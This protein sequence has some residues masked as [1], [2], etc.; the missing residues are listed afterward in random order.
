MPGSLVCLS[1]DQLAANQES[2]MDGRK[3]LWTGWIG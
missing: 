2:K 3:T 1:V